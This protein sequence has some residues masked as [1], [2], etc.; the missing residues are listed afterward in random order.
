MECRIAAAIE[1]TPDCGC[2]TKLVAATDSNAST[3]LHQHSLKNYTEEFFDD[4][5]HIVAVVHTINSKQ[6]HNHFVQSAP[7]GY[8]SPVFQPPRACFIFLS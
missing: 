3:P 5:H 1:S 6:Y 2:E 8:N 4:E 7:I